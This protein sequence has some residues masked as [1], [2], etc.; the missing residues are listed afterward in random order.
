MIRFEMKNQKVIKSEV[1]TNQKSISDL[2]KVIL[3]IVD[4]EYREEDS[5]S[6]LK[7]LSMPRN[8]PSHK[9][10]I[11][12][13]FT[14]ASLARSESKRS[15]QS[16]TDQMMNFNSD[17]L[18]EYFTVSKECKECETVVMNSRN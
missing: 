17:Q 11:S 16:K 6:F 3:P 12:R 1:I 13:Q 10:I 18:V 8:K 9:E 2:N 14:N 15:E 5:I 7:K 4:Q